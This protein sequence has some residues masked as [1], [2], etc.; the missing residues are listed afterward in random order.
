MPVIPITACSGT[1]IGLLRGVNIAII[2][3]VTGS[4][5]ILWEHAISGCIPRR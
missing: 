4:I 2:N 1:N 5:V 3:L